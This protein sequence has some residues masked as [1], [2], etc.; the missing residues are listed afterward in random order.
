[1]NMERYDY[2]KTFQS[3]YELLVNTLTNQDRMFEGMSTGAGGRG[4]NVRVHFAQRGVAILGN[5]GILH[6]D[7][8]CYTCNRFGH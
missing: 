2:T 1:M 7:I 8:R 3:A 4:R 5:N 6:Q